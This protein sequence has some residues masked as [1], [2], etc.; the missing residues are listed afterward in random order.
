MKLLDVFTDETFGIFLDYANRNPKVNL[1][2]KNNSIYIAIYLYINSIKHHNDSL[3]FKTAF[4][5]DFICSI[6]K[7]VN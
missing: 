4:I 5:G 6:T 1:R 7:P 2:V 3:S